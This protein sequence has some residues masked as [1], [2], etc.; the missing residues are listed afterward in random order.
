ME[1]LHGYAVRIPPILQKVTIKA[2]FNGHC[3]PIFYPWF[4]ISTKRH[5]R[6]IFF[7]K[8]SWCSQ[9]DTQ[10]I[11]SGFQGFTIGCSNDILGLTESIHQFVELLLL[12]IGRQLGINGIDG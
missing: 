11:N 10:R 7:C 6:K 5:T 9:S 1:D 8:L 2:E 12:Q 3:L 4:G